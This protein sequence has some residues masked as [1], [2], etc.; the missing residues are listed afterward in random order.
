LALHTPPLKAVASADKPEA[1]GPPTG[2]QIFG[3]QA[4]AKSK[5]ARPSETPDFSR[6]FVN[7]NK[8]LPSSAAFQVS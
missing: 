8:T 5:A 2:F 1:D 7:G 6:V 3:S 4:L